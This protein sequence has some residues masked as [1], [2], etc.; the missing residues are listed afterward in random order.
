M[1]TES[2]KVQISICNYF[3]YFLYYLSLVNLLKRILG[4]F[5]QAGPVVVVSH[6]DSFQTGAENRVAG[7]RFI[8]S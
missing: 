3:F 5:Q 8:Y 1:R 4:A 2:S 6:S 7:I